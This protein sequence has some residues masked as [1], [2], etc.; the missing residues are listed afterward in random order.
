MKVREILKQKVTVL[1]TVDGWHNYHQGLMDYTQIDITLYDFLYILGKRY[2]EAI[3][4][5]RQYPYHGEEQSLYKDEFPVAFI[6]GT[7]PMKQTEDNYI[8][9][10]TNIL[11]M[12]IDKKDNNHIDLDEKIKEIYNLPYVI[13]TPLS[14]SGQGYYV[15]VL[16]ENGKNTKGHYRYLSNLFKSKYNINTDKQCKNI[17]RKRFISYQ[18]NL[19]DVI[20]PMD[21]E[22]VSFKLLDFDSDCLFDNNEMNRMID[23]KPVQFTQ[24]DSILFTQRAIW[25][26]LDNGYSI[27][28]INTD[29]N[30]YSVWYHIGCEF[31]IFDD[32]HEMFIKFS[33][34][35]SKYNDDILTINKKWNNTKNIENVDD[36]CKKWSGIAKNKF[37]NNWWKK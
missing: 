33:N 31:R 10:Y 21:T 6:G 36:V 17:G 25:K 27:D 9:T 34:N 20:K 35:S 8:M 28:D 13:G 22:I 24:K 3:N 32:G 37:G 15:L 16:L 26:L 4:K 29:N 5:Y 18:D 14:I 1:P 19:S 12:D 23:Y 2:K 11:A 30:H 7:F